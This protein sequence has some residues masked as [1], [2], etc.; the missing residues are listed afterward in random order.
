MGALPTFVRKACCLR[1]LRFPLLPLLLGLALWVSLLLPRSL[2]AWLPWPIQCNGGQPTWLPLLIQEAKLLGFPGFQLSHSEAGGQQRV[3]CAVG[4]ARLWPWPE[5]LRTEHVMRYAS[6]SKLLT[7]ARVLQLFELG[8]LHPDSML[9]DALGMTTSPLDRRVKQITVA[10]LLQH[11][12]GFDRAITSDPM[13]AAKPWCPADINRLATVRLD[14]DPGTIYAYSNLGYCLLGALLERY[15]QLPLEAAFQRYLLRP[16][17]LKMEAMHQGQVSPA[18]PQ[19]VFDESESLAD[20]MRIDFDSM[21]ATGAWAGTSG[22]FMIFVNELI[23]PSSTLLGKEGRRRLLEVSSACDDSKWR[24]CHGYGFYRYTRKGRASMFWRDGSLPGVT[25]FA[26]ILD[27]GASVVFLA[28]ARRYD[29]IPIN[30]R[31]GHV[32]YEYLLSSLPP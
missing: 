4:W 21:H 1:I 31:L 23:R 26:A 22:A 13:M 25:S 16:L 11:T 12:A 29:W 17:H 8:V 5:P 28:H 30:D 9:V 7:S 6:M 32:F 10:D 20:L 15:E 24:H 27:N 19:A 14:H 18:E 3:D 2:M